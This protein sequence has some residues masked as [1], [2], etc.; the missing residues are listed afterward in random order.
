MHSQ[1][2]SLSFAWV[3]DESSL[4]FWNL[5]LW[6]L[7]ETVPILPASHSLTP[8]RGWIF[9]ASL[10]LYLVCFALLSRYQLPLTS[11]PWWV[12]KNSVLCQKLMLWMKSLSNEFEFDE[13]PPADMFETLIEW[14]PS[15]H[16]PVVH[17]MIPLILWREVWKFE[18]EPI[19]WTDWRIFIAT[20]INSSL[21]VWKSFYTNCV[22]CYWWYATKLCRLNV[23]RSLIAYLNCSSAYT[24][25]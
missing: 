7:N 15:A 12:A 20:R 4:E 14:L 2:P 6:C 16:Y 10:S 11:L 3:S 23:W 19:V 17:M 25:R 1:T 22:I 5:D 9:L 21:K 18:F 24:F 8:H 13:P